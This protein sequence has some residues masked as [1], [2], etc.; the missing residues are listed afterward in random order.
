MSSP[1]TA[2][3]R[4]SLRCLLAALPLLPFAAACGTAH[5]VVPAVATARPAAGEVVLPV[6]AYLPTTAEVFTT[7]NARAVL[8]DRCMRGFGFSFP[9]P[10]ATLRH[11]SIQDNGV[12]GNKRRY[13]VADATSA[14]RY[15]YHLPSTVERAEDPGGRTVPERPRDPDFALALNGSE[16]VGEV[17]GRELP[18]GGCVAEARRALAEAGSDTGSFSY[19]RRAADIKADSFT[20][21]LRDPRVTG[22]IRKWAACMRAEGY[23][24]VSPVTDRPRFDLDKPLVSRQ[25]IEMAMT[26]AGCKQRTGLVRIWAGVESSYQN[27]HI[28]ADI[29]E[30]NRALTEH[31]SRMAAAAR[32]LAAP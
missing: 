31:R 16:Q 19:A 30:L 8:I 11:L 24:A 21:S 12:Y 22:V 23:R 27:E 32:L 4:T 17:N 25:E 15:G 26:D 28:A 5:P 13:G 1:R 14:A 9:R 7:G 6:N 29:D 2:S 20:R 18:P 10:A 3:P